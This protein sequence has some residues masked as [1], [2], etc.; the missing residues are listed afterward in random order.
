[1][2]DL[3]YHPEAKVEVREAAAFYQRRRQGL[4]E[5]FL[6]EVE[7]IIGKILVNPLRCAKI[8]G[9]FRCCLVRRFPFGIIYSVDGDQIFVAAVA[10]TKRRPGYWKQRVSGG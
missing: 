8:S 10:H 4:G 7:A 5:D 9:R 1:M 2:A 3:S 6:A